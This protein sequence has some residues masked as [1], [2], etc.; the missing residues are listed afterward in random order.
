MVGTG[1]RH[2]RVMVLQNTSRI[3]GLV[4]VKS[5]EV[6]S[7]FVGVAAIR[8]ISRS[9]LDP[10]DFTVLNCIVKGHASLSPPSLRLRLCSRFTL[11]ATYTYFDPKDFNPH[12]IDSVKGHASLSPFAQQKGKKKNKTKKHRFTK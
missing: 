12:P 6:R 3:K 10:N 5:V 4:H 8:D 1:R 11:L 7:V 9:C 2:C